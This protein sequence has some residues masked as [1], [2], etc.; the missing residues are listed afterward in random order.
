MDRLEEIELYEDA[1]AYLYSDEWKA[2][3]RDTLD[4]QVYELYALPEIGD[5][6]A[7]ILNDNFVIDGGAF[8]VWNP[9]SDGLV[10]YDNAG[11][12][13]D[14]KT[15]LT[16]VKLHEDW[17]EVIGWESDRA[18]SWDYFDE[19]GLDKA[20]R[21][22]L[23]SVKP[24]LKKHFGDQEGYFRIPDFQRFV[25]DTAVSVMIED[26]LDYLDH[27]GYEWVQTSEYDVSEYF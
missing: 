22:S 20:Y 8:R 24:L 7:D 18:W 27:L 26:I 17:R 1:Q 6:L 3:N 5:L 9:R 15:L 10:L 16:G 19:I 14:V 23:D 4:E 2:P 11:Y 21:G 12:A 25:M 13:D